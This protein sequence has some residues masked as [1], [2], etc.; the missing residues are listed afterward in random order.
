MPSRTEFYSITI[1]ICVHFFPRLI[2]SANPV[3]SLTHLQIFYLFKED[4][5]VFVYFINLFCYF[6]NWSCDS[7][8]M[9]ISSIR[10]KNHIT[11]W[12]KWQ[13]S[14]C[15]K[16]ALNNEI[17]RKKRFNHASVSD[18]NTMFVAK[19]CCAHCFIFLHAIERID[20]KTISQ[21]S[22]LKKKKKR[23]NRHRHM[24]ELHDVFW[25]IA[26][27]NHPSTVFL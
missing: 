8:M 12:I 4:E 19:K 13:N 26:C 10:E 15:K 25:Q 18:L 1:T 5:T 24:L 20:A 16:A 17:I 2:M 3:F 6:S 23:A 11:W 9:L 21:C 7:I 14:G 27:I 22:N